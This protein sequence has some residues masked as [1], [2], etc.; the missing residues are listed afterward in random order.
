MHPWNNVV[1]LGSQSLSRQEM[2]G[3]AEIPFKLVQQ[4]SDEAC[5][6]GTDLSAKCCINRAVKNGSCYFASRHAGECCF[7]MT[8][9]TMTLSSQGEFLANL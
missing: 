4:D 6:I 1:L 7:V 9:D 8:A 5:V 2:L 3:Q